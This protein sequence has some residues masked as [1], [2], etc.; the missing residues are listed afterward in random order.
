MNSKG[1]ALAHDAVQKHPGGLGDAIFFHEKLLE[2]IDHEKGSRQ[3]LARS[4]FVSG[5][6]LNAEFAKEFAAPAQFLID[7]LEDAQAELAIALDGDNA[8]L[9][10]VMSRVGLEFDPFLEIDQVKFD[11]FGTRPE[12]EVRNH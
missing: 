6:V 5:D 2:L 8:R 10:Q 3:R 11:L 9:G 1:A 12:R 7:A 4:G